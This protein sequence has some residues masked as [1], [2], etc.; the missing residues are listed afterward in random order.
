MKR[1]CHLSVRLTPQEKEDLDKISREVAMPRSDLIRRA[2]L[3]LLIQAKANK[4]RVT[5]P[6]RFEERK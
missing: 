3:A 6:L 1:I 5:L 4:G 2:V